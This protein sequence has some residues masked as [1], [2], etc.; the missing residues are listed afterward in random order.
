MIA[1][2]VNAGIA[3]FLGVCLFTGGLRGSVHA[4]TDLPK[5]RLFCWITLLGAAFFF[6]STYALQFRSDHRQPDNDTFFFFVWG[7]VGV[8]ALSTGINAFRPRRWKKPA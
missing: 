7:F 6:L 8:L 5:A 2:D 1:L 4:R 3:G